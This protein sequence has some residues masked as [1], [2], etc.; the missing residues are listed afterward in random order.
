MFGR[1]DGGMD[2]W[3]AGED[4]GKPQSSEGRFKQ[5]REKTNS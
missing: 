5:K 4:E 1:R 2:G 3:R